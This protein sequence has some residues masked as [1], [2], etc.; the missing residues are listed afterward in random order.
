[1]AIYFKLKNQAEKCHYKIFLVDG[2]TL[3]MKRRG[4][5]VDANKEHVLKRAMDK[6]SSN[7]KWIRH[8]GRNLKFKSQITSRMYGPGNFFSGGP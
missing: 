1:M 8:P 7:Y 4:S 2:M 5:K 3:M 6:S